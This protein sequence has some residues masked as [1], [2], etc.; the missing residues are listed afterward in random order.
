MSIFFFFFLVVVPVLG[1][2]QNETWNEA[3][4]ACDLLRMCSQGEVKEAVQ[5]SEDTAKSQ[6][7]QNPQMMNAVGSPGR[8]DTF[9]KELHIQILASAMGK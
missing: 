2:V 5:G 7:R 8:R 9:A 1:R 6:L 4:C 3:L